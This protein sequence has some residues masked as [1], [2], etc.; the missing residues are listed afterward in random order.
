MK[1]F[2]T[3]TNLFTLCLTLFAEAGPVQTTD[4]KATGNDISPEMREFYV[5]QLLENLKKDLIYTQFSE[6]Y[7]IPEHNGKVAKFRR[8]NKFAP[9]TTPLTEGITPEGT[10]LDF[11]EVLVPVY[12]YGAY[13]LLS[14]RILVEAIDPMVTVA[15]EGFSDQAGETLDILTRDVLCGGTQ[16][17]YAPNVSAA[18]TVTENELRSEMDKTA[19]INMDVIYDAARL[20]KRSGVKTINGSYICIVHPDVAKDIKRTNEWQEMVKYQHPEKI[21]KGEIGMIDNIRFIESN[22]APIWKSAGKDV[23]VYGSVVFGKGAYGEVEI[24]GEKLE[25]I[26]NQPGSAGSADPLKQRGSAGWKTTYAV[27]RTSEDAIVRIESASSSNAVEDA[28]V[29]E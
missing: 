24:D 11:S 25:F 10:P 15:V 27:A 12:Q 21:Y 29:T 3:F 13:A 28:I 14:D 6:K 16:V 26:V 8:M 9:A 1:T 19:I 7:P 22:N 23:A 2:N 20:L 18:G 4:L 17:Y 5:K